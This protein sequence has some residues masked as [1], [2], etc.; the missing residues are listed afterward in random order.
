MTENGAVESINM[1]DYGTLT[2]QP[3]AESTIEALSDLGKKA[4]VSVARSIQ[5]LM[6]LTNEHN[7]NCA[8]VKQ[9][10]AVSKDPAEYLE[11]IRKN[12]PGQDKELD[13]INKRIEA[14]E[15]KL[16]EEK[17]KA[18]EIAAKYQIDTVSIDEAEAAR[19]MT[20][21][22]A[23]IIRK[24]YSNLET[25]AQVVDEDVSLEGGIMSLIPKADSLR[26]VKFGGSESTGERT[27]FRTDKVYLNGEVI[28]RKTKV[29]GGG[30]TEKSTLS[31]LAAKLNSD[32]GALRDPS[33]KVTVMDLT[34]AMYDQLGIPRGT[35]QAD[36]EQ[37]E[38]NFT[39]TKTV[40]FM[41]NGEVIPS[42]VT[43]K[44]RIVFDYDQWL[45]DN[46]VTESDVA[47]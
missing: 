14:M 33:N 34:N 37:N 19:Q 28:V 31:I 17:T 23:P 36:I 3:L 35:K 32:F 26:G 2:L 27:T 1:E 21:K 18:H 41:K 40:N 9:A 47:V 44:I 39:F 5:V 43:S 10:S 15:K 24:H 38:L 22:S 13:A 42:D 16:S 20:Q 12:N 25:I 7:L 45:K 4:R 6:S 8:K 11:T 30:E 46:Q 29:P